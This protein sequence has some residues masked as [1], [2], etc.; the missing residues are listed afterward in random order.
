MGTLSRRE[1]MAAAMSAC[2]ATEPRCASPKRAPTMPGGADGAGG[3]S[4]SSNGD[5]ALDRSSAST[6]D[7][8]DDASRAADAS[9]PSSDAGAGADRD[10]AASAIIDT[11]VHF[12]DPARPVPSGRPSSVPWPD[13]S[14]VLYRTTLPA[15]YLALA[16]PL[17]ISSAIVIEASWWLE[18][19]QW[20]LDLIEG[21]PAFAGLVGNLSEVLGMP[22]FDDT[23][24]KL[25]GNWIVF[26]ASASCRHN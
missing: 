24:T 8:S 13:P 2:A 21:N 11:H 14:D 7:A 10:A 25:A 18:D 4:S 1:F 20:I 19:N 3:S 23:L 5:A 6:G 26:G 17:G 16:K 9:S 12:F 15:D 22:T